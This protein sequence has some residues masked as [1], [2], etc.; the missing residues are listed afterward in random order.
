MCN[1]AKQVGAEMLR[2][3]SAAGL[4]AAVLAT[5]CASRGDVPPEPLK[6]IEKL[7]LLPVVLEND[8]HNPNY[9]AHH[10]TQPMPS[11]QPVPSYVAG[12][13]SAGVGAALLVAGIA[14]LIVHGIEQEQKKSQTQLEQAY[15][16]LEF[17]PADSLNARVQALLRDER[18]KVDMDVD[19]AE[20]LTARRA[21]DYSRLKTKGEAVLDIRVNDNGYFKSMRAGGVSPMLGITASLISTESGE[22]IE[23][24]YY[25]SDWRESKNNPR[26]FTSPP[27][28]I[29]KSTEELEQNAAA[30]KEGL[31]QTVSKIAKQIVTDVRRRARGEAAD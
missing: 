19:P 27:S 3:F 12:G 13:S 28:T 23:S 29:Y 4:A 30:A 6:P 11:S 14:A 25:W 24:Y 22:A 21:D 18:L 31:E 1:W 7:V 17:R 9:F 10:A 8:I 2:R 16:A 20:A 15:E 5:G 26:W